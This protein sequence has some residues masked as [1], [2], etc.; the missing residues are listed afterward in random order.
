MTTQVASGRVLSI[1]GLSVEYATRVPGSRTKVVAKAVDG[2]K[3]TTYPDGVVTRSAPERSTP[4][5][6]A[7][8]S[9][10]PLTPAVP[11]RPVHKHH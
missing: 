2:W 3:T 6:I 7:D 8:S 5:P 1:E 10:A 9:H 4:T 11:A